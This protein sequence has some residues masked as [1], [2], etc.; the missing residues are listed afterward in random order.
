MLPNKHI[1][2]RIHLSKAPHYIITIYNV[3]NKLCHGISLQSCFMPESFYH[4]LPDACFFPYT[5][6]QSQKSIFLL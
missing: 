1:I 4:I 2:V 3:A 5:E 6:C